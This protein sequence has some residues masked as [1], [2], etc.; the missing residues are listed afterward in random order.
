VT[1]RWLAALDNSIC[2]RR[3]RAHGGA[4]TCQP[5]SC[6]PGYLPRGRINGAKCLVSFAHSSNRTES[7]GRRCGIPVS[8]HDRQLRHRCLFPLPAMQIKQTNIAGR[9]LRYAYGA[10]EQL[11]ELADLPMEQRTNELCDRLRLPTAKRMQSRKL[12]LK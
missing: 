8:D 3:D 2:C 6:F 10:G 12:F 1:R 11:D 7:L 9:Q 4:C 5:V